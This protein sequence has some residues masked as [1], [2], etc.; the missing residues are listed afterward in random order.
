MNDETTPQKSDESARINYIPRSQMKHLTREAVLEEMGPSCISVIALML[1]LCLL[2]ESVFWSQ[3]V[4]VTTATTTTG[5]VVPAGNQRIVQHLEGGIVN[6]ILI[7]DGDT[8][9]EGQT[10]IRFDRTQHE[11]EL[12]QIRAR[13]T[14]LRIRETRLR[15]QIDNIEP[16]FGDLPQK[17]PMLVE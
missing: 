7:A 4:P 9:N 11:A 16:D 2:V 15:A 5:K 1:I 6:E 3:T 13:E 12:G 8:V 14:A 10:L 17:V